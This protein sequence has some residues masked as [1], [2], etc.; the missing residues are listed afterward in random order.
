MRFML[1]S[2][3]HDTLVGMRL[4]GIEGCIAQNPAEVK[5]ALF[6]FESDQTVGIILITEILS[7]MCADEIDN[8]KLHTAKPLIV[9]IPDRHSD[10][11]DS[12]S[13]MRYV[14]E[15]IGIKL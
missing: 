1:I 14:R 5:D 13:V 2:D 9:V 7:K 6:K 8:F 10:G 12:D 4:A 15:A 3:N 11:R